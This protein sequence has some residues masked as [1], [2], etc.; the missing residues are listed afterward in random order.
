LA[1]A[2][3]ANALTGK[4]ALNPGGL[5][6]H[7]V[8]AAVAHMGNSLERTIRVTIT[9]ER[10]DK[11][12]NAVGNGN[13]INAAASLAGIAPRTIYSWLQQGRKYDEDRAQG[14]PI[15]SK[16]YLYVRLVNGV[17]AARA[18]LEARLVATVTGRAIDCED[19]RAASWFLERSFHKSWGRKSVAT[20]E[21]DA[22]N[23]V[24]VQVSWVDSIVKALKA[25]DS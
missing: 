19:W 1:S 17:R 3:R 10:I 12:I 9:E 14:D 20:I 8:H 4:Q 16:A 7:A 21:G 13:S 18:D 11:I 24:Q 5:S 6:I 15:S 25:E 22:D 2:R 23:P